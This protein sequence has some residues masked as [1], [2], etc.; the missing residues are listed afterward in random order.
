ML[1]IKTDLKISVKHL[2]RGKMRHKLILLMLTMSIIL[3]GCVEA[4]DEKIG[5]TIPEKTVKINYFEKNRIIDEEDFPGF[6]LVE[7][8]YYV[9]SEN[10]SLTLEAETG[11]GV[12]EVDENVT[13]PPGYRIY[14]G[15]ESYNLSG[16][17]ILVQYKVFDK[18]DSLTDTINAT[19]EDIY[20]KRGYKYVPVND[21]FKGTKVV[22]ESNVSN[23]TDKNRIM[24]LFGF[25]TVIGVVGVQDSKDKSLDESLK[26]LDIVS[27]RLNIK[28]KEVKVVKMS[29]IR[30]NNSNN[31]GNMDNMSNAENKTYR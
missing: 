5:V 27:N 22:L 17:Y 4:N 16:R 26:I 24:I 8:V 1:I 14:G 7:N 21:K 9:A 13:I 3:S 19:A 6:E 12:Y 11:H 2:K 10:L 31:T 30:S 23:S 28:T 25:G 15:S 29:T 18:N 20:I